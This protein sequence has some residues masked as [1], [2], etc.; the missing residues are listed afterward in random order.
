MHALPEFNT[1][2]QYF[3]QTGLGAILAGTRWD[4]DISTFPLALEEG[5]GY[6]I[7]H[8]YKVWSPGKTINGAPVRPALGSSSKSS[9]QHAQVPMITPGPGRTS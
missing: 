6:F 3:W 5:A 4:E 1:R 2:G 7:G 9:S 8:T